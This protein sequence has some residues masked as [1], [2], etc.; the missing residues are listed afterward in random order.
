MTRRFQFSLRALLVDMG[1]L[2][3]SLGVL[4]WARSMSDFWNPCGDDLAV[5]VTGGVLAPIMAVPL[6]RYWGWPQSLFR[7]WCLFVAII[8]GVPFVSYHWTRLPFP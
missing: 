1:L 4:S 2:C 8:A 5:V 3:F 6:R 7:S